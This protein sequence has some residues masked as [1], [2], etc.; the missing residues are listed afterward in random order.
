MS[1]ASSACPWRSGGGPLYAAAA[2]QPMNS[3]D[4]AAAPSG[5]HGRA[6]AGAMR[7]LLTSMVTAGSSVSAQESPPLVA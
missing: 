2:V 4:P 5:L 6:A 1:P 7:A 3:L